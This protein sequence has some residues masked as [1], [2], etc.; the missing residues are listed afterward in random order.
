MKLRE[1]SPSTFPTLKLKGIHMQL[2]LPNQGNGVVPP[3]F[4]LDLTPFTPFNVQFFVDHPCAYVMNEDKR[5]TSLKVFDL[6]HL[7]LDRTMVGLKES[8]SASHR[9][10]VHL[11]QK[12]VVLADPRIGLALLSEYKDKVALGRGEESQLEKLRK[13]KGVTRLDFLGIILAR[14]P[15]Y[16]YFFYLIFD[17]RKTKPAFA[18]DWSIYNFDAAEKINHPTA[19]FRKGSFQ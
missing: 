16:A 15:R 2:Q 12:D 13:E 9:H 11:T 7:E 4:L 1:I 19:T 17:D 8:L 10:Q 6:E 3:A 18:W 5:S 14:L